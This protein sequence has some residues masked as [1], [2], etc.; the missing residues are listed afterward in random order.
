MVSPPSQREH[1]GVFVV[2]GG[3]VLSR[4]CL[5]NLRGPGTPLFQQLTFVGAAHPHGLGKVGQ[6][7]LFLDGSEGTSALPYALNESLSF[8][9]RLKTENRKEC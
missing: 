1:I 2:G 9:M 3:G 7:H 5:G 8:S 6:K 4:K